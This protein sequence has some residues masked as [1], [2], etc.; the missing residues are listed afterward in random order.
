MNSV[1]IIGNIGHDLEVRYTGSGKAVLNF[2]IAVS[3]F[4]DE[5]EWFRIVLWDK[6]A[7]NT[8]N[9][10]SKGSKVGVSGR[11]SKNKYTN[12]EGIEIEQV[13]IVGLNINFLS[14]QDG[15]QKKNNQVQNKNKPVNTWK[16]AIDENPFVE[17]DDV[18]DINDDDLPF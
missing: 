1:N 17:N 7:T 3:N 4:R 14:H 10:C 18:T 6:L 2:N 5:T 13:E 12:N 16:E 9:Y 11:L 15:G 8:A